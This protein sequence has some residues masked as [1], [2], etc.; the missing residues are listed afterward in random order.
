MPIIRNAE[1]KSRYSSP[2]QARLTPITDAEA[3]ALTASSNFFNDL[4]INSN[5]G[6]F[7]SSYINP[8]GSEKGTP[9]VFFTLPG[10]DGADTVKSLQETGMENWWG[11]DF[12][13]QV[14]M[15]NVFVYP[16]RSE[17]PC[18]LQLGNDQNGN[19]QLSIS[20][21]LEAEEMPQRVTPKPNGWQRFWNRIYSGFY[22]DV[23]QPYDKKQQSIDNI[24]NSVSQMKDHRQKTDT[25]KESHAAKRLI[26]DAACLIKQAGS[27]LFCRY[28]PC[29]RNAFQY[30]ILCS[31]VFINLSAAGSHK[32]R[33]R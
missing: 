23:C 12:W 31:N 24:K 25:S 9:R 19:W 26:S 17:K 33:R 5:N 30:D 32:L 2:Q 10:A 11:K 8:N 28:T 16:A 6:G 4:G 22:K 3:Q 27:F 14:Q 13:N 20:R 15:G 21:P 29:C 7:E 18:Q 1:P